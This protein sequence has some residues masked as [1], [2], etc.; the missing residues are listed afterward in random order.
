VIV[1]R[2]LSPLQ[3]DS[4][5]AR[6]AVKNQWMVG[7]DVMVDEHSEFEVTETE[8]TFLIDAVYQLKPTADLKIRHTAFGGFCVKARKD[9]KRI[10]LDKD[11][12]VALPN[13]HHLKPETDWP[14]RDW[15]AFQITLDS[16]KTISIAVVDHPENPPT[17]WHNL[18]PISMLNPCIAAPAAVS[19]PAGKELKLRYR[20][21]VHDGPA[22]VDGIN[23]LASEFR[24]K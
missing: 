18:E 4:S 2:S 8:D 1:N 21:I 6:F 5:G 11:G 17:L 22:A 20:M 9:G 19:L 13:P 14:S 10:Y 23:E 24:A 7:S 12:P 16:G 15:Y 3:A